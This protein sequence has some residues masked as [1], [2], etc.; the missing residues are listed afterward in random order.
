MKFLVTAV[1]QWKSYLEKNEKLCVWIRLQNLK[2][3]S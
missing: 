1:K 2:D 3:L